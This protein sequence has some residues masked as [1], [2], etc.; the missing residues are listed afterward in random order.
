MGDPVY[1][2][3]QDQSQE[4]TVYH[5]HYQLE[6]PGHHP[7]QGHSQEEADLQILTPIWT[8]YLSEVSQNLPHTCQA[9]TI[10][11]HQE[12]SRGTRI[13]SFHRGDQDPESP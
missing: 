9:G 6:D 13:T 7:A 8:H 12:D 5:R 10:H 3:A 1:P 11:N 2:P 4:E